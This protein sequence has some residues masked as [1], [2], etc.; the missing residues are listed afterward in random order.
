MAMY[1]TSR[2]LVAASLHLLHAFSDRNISYVCMGKMTSDSQEH[3]FGRRRHM[4]GSNYWTS[5]RQFFESEGIVRQV[6]LV[7]LSGYSVSEI[8]KEMKSA[9]AAR[10]LS[11]QNVVEIFVRD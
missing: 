5:I 3:A 8:S 6:N 1:Y 7:S 11:D 9:A 4:A 2:G 10:K